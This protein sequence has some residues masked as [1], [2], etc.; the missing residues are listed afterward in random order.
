[1]A[2]F[3]PRDANSLFRER[4]LGGDAKWALLAVIVFLLI[5]IVALYFLA[6]FGG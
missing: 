2:Q 1:M 3:N 5:D 4:D 6:P